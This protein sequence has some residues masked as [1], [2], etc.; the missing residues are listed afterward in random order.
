MQIDKKH[1][2][3]GV[4]AIAF[5]KNGTYIRHQ[6][7]LLSAVSYEERKIVEAFLHLKNGKAAEFDLMSETL[8]D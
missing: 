1:I 3:G 4:Q 6:T 5:K 7:E 8:F 2:L